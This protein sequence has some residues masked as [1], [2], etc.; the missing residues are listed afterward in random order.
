MKR[1][2]LYLALCA[3]ACIGVGA[4]AA[5]DFQPAQLRGF[6]RTELTVQRSGGS[7]TFHIWVAATPDQQEQGLMWIQQLPADH[8][9]VFPLRA[10]RPMD[11]WMKNTYV[12][13]DML[14]FDASGKITHI[15]ENAKPLSEDIISSGGVVAGVVEILGG[16]AA[17]RGIHI[18]DHL[19]YSGLGNR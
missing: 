13:L 3:M 18:G 9:M 12:P 17:R 10:P 2:A 19:K 11:M 14:F 16:E 4:C 6:A 15:Q 7:D 5:Q 8:G 1:L